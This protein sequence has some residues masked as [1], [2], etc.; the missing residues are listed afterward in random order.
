MA[1]VIIDKTEYEVPDAVAHELDEYRRIC[2][3]M[4]PEELETELLSI[5]NKVDAMVSQ[6]TAYREKLKITGI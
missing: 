1:K 6:I 4:T 3:G 2:A 5:S